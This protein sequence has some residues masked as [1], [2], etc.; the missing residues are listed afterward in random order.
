MPPWERFCELC[1][2]RFGP[3]VRGSRLA[4]LG[5]LPFTSTV[6]DYPTVSRPWHAMRRA[7][8]LFQALHCHYDRRYLRIQDDE[9]TGET[10]SVDVS[11]TENLKRLIDVGKALLKRQVCKVNIETGK[12]E[13]DLER[14]TNVEELTHFARVLSEESKARST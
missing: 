12:N 8:V 3:P 2:L 11:T 5:R 7:F 1:L 10:A 9:L 13:P 6:H 14:G 4:E